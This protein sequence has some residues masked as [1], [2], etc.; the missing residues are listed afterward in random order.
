MKRVQPNYQWGG[1]TVA[2]PDDELITME[3]AEEG[4]QGVIDRTNK[5]LEDELD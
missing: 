4:V 2:G 5:R 3:D 1:E